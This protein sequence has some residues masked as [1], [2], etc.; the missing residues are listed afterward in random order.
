MKK[1]G[2]LYRSDLVVYKQWRNYDISCRREVWS[3]A[4]AILYNLHLNLATAFKGFVQIFL[5][6]FNLANQA[7]IVR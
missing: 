6:Y 7:K 2:Q 3:C 5:Y 1:I 4:S